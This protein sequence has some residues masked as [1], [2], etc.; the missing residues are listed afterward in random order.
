MMMMMPSIPNVHI[1]FRAVS[2]MSSTQHSS[3]ERE[4]YVTGCGGPQDCQMSRLPHFLDNWLTDR[5]DI[6]IM[7]CLP[8]Y[9]RKIVGTHFCSAQY[10]NKQE[11]HPSVSLSLFT[12]K[13]E[14]KNNVTLYTQTSVIDVT[15]ELS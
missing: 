15:W 12:F 13:E 1:S 3:V 7:C 14:N 10:P 8:F 5:G 11:F 4:T 9:P 6:S 2:V